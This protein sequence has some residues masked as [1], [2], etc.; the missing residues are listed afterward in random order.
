[1][2]CDGEACADEM[3]AWHLVGQQH[4]VGVTGGTDQA[5]NFGGALLLSQADGSNDLCGSVVEHCARNL[6]NAAIS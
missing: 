5:G 2:Q 1:M 3:G 6:D 4:G